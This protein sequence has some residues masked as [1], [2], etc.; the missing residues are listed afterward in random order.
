ML[1]PI[2]PPP[3]ITTLV[4]RGSCMGPN[5]TFSNRLRATK[6]HFVLDT[7]PSIRRAARTELL[8]Q[9]AHLAQIKLARSQ[10]GECIHV[11]KLIGPRLPKIWQ[12]THCK[13]FQTRLKLAISE[14]VKNGETLAFFLIGNPGHDEG[15]F[16][17]GG[18]FMQ[19]FLYLEMR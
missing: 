5:F 9:F 7:F 17:D 6:K 3:T 13:L 2:T 14:L 11:K 18:K 19:L 1:Q 8:R 10:V 16:G 12:F 15:L 4:S